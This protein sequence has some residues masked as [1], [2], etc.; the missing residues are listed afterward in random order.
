VCGGLNTGGGITNYMENLAARNWHR[1][2][3][4]NSGSFPVVHVDSLTDA[5]TKSLDMPGA[6]I[7]SDQMTTLKDIAQTM[8]AQARSYV[9]VIMPTWLIML[10]ISLLEVIARI[11]KTRPF[12]SVAQ[13]EFLTK[14]WKPN[15]GKAIRQ[16]GWKPMRLEE[17]IRRFLSA[18]PSLSSDELGLRGAAHAV[19]GSGLRRAIGKL[20]LLTAGGLL[21]YWL[22]FFTV[23]LAPENPPPGYFVFQRSFTVSD[24]VLALVLITAGG[25]LLGEDAARRVIGRRLSLVC[26]GALIFLGGL[27]ISFN[28]QNGIYAT[29]SIDLVL[30]MAINVWCLGFGLLLVFAFGSDAYQR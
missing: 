30:E 18:R 7:V 5:T 29:L 16:L 26:A 28:F 19:T 9:P 3:F 23:G 8:R 25:F 20:E 27:D 24:I 4:I 13:I 11:I 21:L 22:L 6:Y 15:P 1:V 10:G 14:G 12:A 2:P 17:G